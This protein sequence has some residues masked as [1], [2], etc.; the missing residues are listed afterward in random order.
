MKGITYF[1][2]VVTVFR[3]SFVKQAVGLSIVLRGIIFEKPIHLKKRTFRQF[4]T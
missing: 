1:F 4:A 2:S 3:H